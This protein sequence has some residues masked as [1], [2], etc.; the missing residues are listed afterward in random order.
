M[1]LVPLP[2]T[3]QKSK[4]QALL[5]TLL[6]DFWKGKIE[7]DTARRVLGYWQEFNSTDT[8]VRDLFKS[9]ECDSDQLVVVRDIDYQSMC[10]HHL[11]PF[12]GKVHI[13]YIP[14][15]QVL[16]LSKFGRIVT[17]FAKNPQLQE[18]LT[19]Q[20]GTAIMENLS[21]LGV[22]VVAEGFH[23]CMMAR[24]ILKQSS[25]TRTSFISGAFKTDAVARQET[26]NLMLY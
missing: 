15:G 22:I 26:L 5:E 3:T 17:H 8:D 20:I 14:N 1:K 4:N 6:I 24:G 13:G 18:R 2:A 23:T 16:G 11:L 21:P 25:S 10:E 9:F 19:Q 12:Y 7:L